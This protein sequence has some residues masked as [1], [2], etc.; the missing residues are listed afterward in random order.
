MSRS[1]TL[2]RISLAGFESRA[3]MLEAIIASLT[4]SMFFAMKHGDK[5]QVAE[6]RGRLSEAKRRYAECRSY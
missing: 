2:N 3:E 6:I 5:R 4:D 1:P